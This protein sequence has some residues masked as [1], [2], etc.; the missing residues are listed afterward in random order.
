M[1]GNQQIGLQREN[2]LG[3]QSPDIA[4]LR[5]FGRISREIRRAVEPDHPVSGTQLI[6][7]LGNVPTGGDD[8]L[9]SSRACVAGCKQSD[10]EQ[11]CRQKSHAATPSAK[12][13]ISESQ[14]SG[15]SSPPP[16]T[17]KN[18]Q[19]TVPSAAKQSSEVMFR[20]FSVE[21]LQTA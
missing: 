7:D 4:D 13:L 19:I 3:R 21:V 20:P 1:R 8:T 15:S 12:P 11:Y 10:S 2:A 9:R 5:F 17:G 6:D 16:R 14:A 18:W